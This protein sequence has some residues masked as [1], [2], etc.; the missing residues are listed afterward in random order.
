MYRESMGLT[1]IKDDL[2]DTGLSAEVVHDLPCL[3]EAVSGQ[4]DG[5]L[6]CAALVICSADINE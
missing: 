3:I 2:L 6:D 4:V 5:G 1:T